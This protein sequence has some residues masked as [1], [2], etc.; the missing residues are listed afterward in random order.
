VVGGTAAADEGK[1]DDRQAMARKDQ[2]ASELMRIGHY[3]DNP[4][5]KWEYFEETLVDYDP[6][7]I[8]VKVGYPFHKTGSIIKQLGSGPGS[9]FLVYLDEPIHWNNYVA[10]FNIKNQKYHYKDLDNHGCLDKDN[11]VIC[12]YGKWADITIKGLRK[13]MPVEYVESDYSHISSIKSTPGIVSGVEKDKGI[14]YMFA[15]APVSWFRAPYAIDTDYIKPEH[16]SKY[17]DRIVVRSTYLMWKEKSPDTLPP[18]KLTKDGE[19]FIFDET[20]PL[21]E[22]KKFCDEAV[23]EDEHKLRC[24]LGG[25]MFHIMPIVASRHEGTFH[26]MRLEVAQDA[27]AYVVSAEEVE[28]A[29]EGTPMKVKHLRGRKFRFDPDSGEWDEVTE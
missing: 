7:G 10:Q 14:V 28:A 27:A 9:M 29:I 18:G 26:P 25:A 21:E 2:G 23:E 5:E 1:A 12:I 19:E 16:I 20:I 24:W 22:V 11:N 3:D 6:H 8:K 15:A 13:N 17:T 4:G